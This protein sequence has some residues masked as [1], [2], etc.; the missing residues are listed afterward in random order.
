MKRFFALA[1]IVT[2]ILASCGKADVIIRTDIENTRSPAPE[3]TTV[4]TALTAANRAT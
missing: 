2:L 3:M 1:V 4:A